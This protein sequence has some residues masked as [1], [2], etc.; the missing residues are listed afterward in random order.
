M[1]FKGKKKEKKNPIFQI[2]LALCTTAL[3]WTTSAFAQDG[4]AITLYVENDTRY[5]GGPGSDN[6][7]TNGLKLS[8]TSANDHIPEW[9]RPFMANSKLLRRLQ[10]DSQSNFSISL[11]HQI[12]TPNNTGATELLPDDR[13]YAGW[14]Y[15]GLGAHFKDRLRSH[16]FELDIGIVG[17]EALGREVQNSYHQLI[18][19]RKAYGWEHQIAFEPTLQL[20]YQE[21]QRFIEKVS[22]EYGNYFDLIPFYG[23][24]LGNV[25]VNGYGGAMVRLGAQLPNDFGPSRAS[26]FDGDLFVEPK[27]ARVEEPSKMSLYGFAGARGIV[28]LRNIFLDG[29]TFRDSHRVHKNNFVVETEFGAAL[30]VRPW[31]LA[32]RFVTRTAEF[33]K[34]RGVNSFASISVSYA[35]H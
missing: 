14:L 30:Q 22:E 12:Y 9:A 33:R 2:T 1:L 21:R 27:Q 15:V 3:A 32:W 23:V 35:F 25:A 11:G 16:A 31:N 18:G 28:V 13:P 26:S 7:Y 34:N 29:N 24:S 6:A 4:R 8:Y 20:S 5:I 19:V 17:P 10:Q